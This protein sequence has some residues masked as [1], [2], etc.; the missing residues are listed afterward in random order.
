V[1]D[2]AQP[3]EYVDDECGTSSGP[4]FVLTDA[5]DAGPDGEA[6][7]E[8]TT[9][10][11]L[12]RVYVGVINASQAEAG[13][14][15]LKCCCR[16]GARLNGLTRKLRRARVDDRTAWRRRE[17][18]A[19]EL[20]QQRVAAVGPRDNPVAT[21]TMTVRVPPRSEGAAQI[22]VRFRASSN[23]LGVGE[24]PV[25]ERVF[26]VRRA[27]T[28]CCRSSLRRPPATARRLPRTGGRVPVAVVARMG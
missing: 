28:A 16:A 27:R 4:R 25:I 7:T 13:H 10:K 11:I 23:E 17:P 1:A 19:G 9:A 24:D 21:F 6:V 20:S 26:S 18:G 8:S 15:T 14:T 2:N 3:C 12:L 5:A 22:P